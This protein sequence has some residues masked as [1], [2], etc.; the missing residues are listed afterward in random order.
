MDDQQVRA[1]ALIAAALNHSGQGLDAGVLAGLADQL[2]PYIAGAARMTLL[3]GGT[4]PLNINSV[5]AT[6]DLE[7]EDTAG[8]KVAP[9]AGT[10][11]VAT[12]SNP[13]VLGVGAQAAGTDANGVPII[14]FPLTAASA[15]TATLSV[16][17]TDAAGNPLLGPSGTAIPDAA[18]VTVTVNPGAAAAEVFTVPGA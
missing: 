1:A 16:H 8:D 6:A 10:V 4:V 5:N 17:C 15:G 3:L 13:A 18:P 2:V 9:P 14:T 7:F 11:A 12:S